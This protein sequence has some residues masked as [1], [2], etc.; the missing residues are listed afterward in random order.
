MKG[1]SARCVE[2]EVKSVQPLGTAE[3]GHAF[4]TVLPYFLQCEMCYSKRL[5]IREVLT[6][7][8]RYFQGSAAV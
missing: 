6:D 5:P 1:L 2:I 7:I 3:V 4:G 8:V